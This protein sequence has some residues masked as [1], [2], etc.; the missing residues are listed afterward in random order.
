MSDLYAHD[1]PGPHLIRDGQLL[2][3][4]SRPFVPE[5]EV[6]AEGQV[7]TDEP[8]WVVPLSIWKTSRATLRRHQHPVAVLLGADADLRDLAEPDGTLNPA[9][10]A[11]IAVDFPVYTDGRGYSLAQLLRTQYQWTGELRAVGDV[12]I[13]TI[14]YQARVGFN[15]FLVKPGHD[16]KKALAAFQTFTVHY[17]KTYRAPTPAAA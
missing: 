2:A 8:G 14:H 4:T 15:S 5:P 13:D 1:A 12:M 6:A 3:D 17:Q 16:P 7:P 9:G 11:F 10:I